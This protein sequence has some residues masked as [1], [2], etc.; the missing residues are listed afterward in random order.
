MS[1]RLLETWDSAAR[2]PRALEELRELWAYRS[3]VAALVARNVKVR[4]KRSV[5]GVAWSMLSPAGT[6]VILSV[7]FSRV[8]ADAAPGYPAYLLPGLL[9][10]MF[11]SQSTA[12]V[13][14]EVA[15]GVDLWRRVKLPKTAP[16][17]ATVLTS[18]VN[19]GFA[20][21]P[22]GVLLLVLRR[23][24]GLA[25]LSVPVVLLGATLFAFGVSLAISAATLHFADMADAYGIAVTAWMY[26]TP[27]IY[28]IGILP[29]RVRA[30]VAANPMTLYVEAFRR[31]FYE[32]ASAEPAT[33][34]A[35]LGIGAGTLVVGW[36][37]F[38]RLA[39]EVPYRG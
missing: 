20:I 17:L 21:V 11:F 37:L 31:P 38:T 25:L 8:F 19:L 28:P 7:V 12:S 10:W 39:D 1:D 34:L 4:Y 15:G 32:N 30:V 14:A 23:P 27:V 29:E 18:L 2:P 33:L 3:L 13:A 35:C 36:L 24:V 26:A 22:L 6:M 16:A 9:L 5:L